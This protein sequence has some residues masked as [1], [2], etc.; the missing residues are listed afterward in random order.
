MNIGLILSG[1]FAKGAYQIGALKALDEFVP[2]EEIKYL[3]CSSIGVLNG[4]AYRTGNLDLAREMWENVCEDGT[5]RLISQVLRSSLISQNVKLLCSEKKLPQSTFYCSLFNIGKRTVVY[6]DISAAS[7]DELPLYLR[8]SVAFPIYNKAVKI[9]DESF[10]DGGIVDNIPVYPLMK[11]SLDYIICVYFDGKCYKFE[12]DYFDNKI[13]K[14]TFPDQGILKKSLVLENGRTNEM[15]EQ[16]YERT[17]HL[18]RS[19][20]YDGYD[21]IESVCRSIEQTGGYGK[22][23][24]LRIT[25][26]VVITNL[27]KITKK[28]TKRKVIT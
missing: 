12:N 8:A 25:G 14:I 24:N 23:E 1:G 18:L 26:D 13:I 3:S 9:G 11:H 17:V 4:Y 15:I 20:F 19:V 28:L 27:N 6:R 16:G 2:K 21:D 10:F 22:N 5:R 7:P